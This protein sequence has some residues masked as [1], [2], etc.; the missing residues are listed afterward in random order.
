MSMIT[1]SC[2][3]WMARWESTNVRGVLLWSN[4]KAHQTCALTNDSIAKALQRLPNKESRVLFAKF[5]PVPHKP[6]SMQIPAALWNCTTRQSFKSMWWTG[7]LSVVSCSQ[8]ISNPSLQQAFILVNPNATLQLLWTLVCT[9]QNLYL[10]IQKKVD[11]TFQ[12]STS[13]IH[14][15]HDAWTNSAGKNCFFGIYGS[16]ID[17]KF[18]YQEYLMWLLQMSGKHTGP[19][20]LVQQNHEDQP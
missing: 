12:A 18:E 19:F 15:T 3:K 20:H 11:S 4:H 17:E 10:G 9:L 6:Q 8:E 7:S 16:F 2:K 1:T 5:P 13:T 14:Y